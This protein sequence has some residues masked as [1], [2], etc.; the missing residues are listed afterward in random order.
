MGADLQTLLLQ[1]P[2]RPPILPFSQ[3]AGIRKDP[4]KQERTHIDLQTVTPTPFT[5]P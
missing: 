4:L 5:S 1:D 2:K 3:V